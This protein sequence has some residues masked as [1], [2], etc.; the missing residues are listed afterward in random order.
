M[1]HSDSQY[2][3]LRQAECH[4][5]QLKCPIWIRTVKNSH[6][7]SQ[8]VTDPDSENVRL[9]QPESDS[10]TFGQRECR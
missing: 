2:V 7:D 1:S 3:T 10:V 5:G 9:E 6:S 8:N 4:F